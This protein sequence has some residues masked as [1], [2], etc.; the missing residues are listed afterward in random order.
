MGH[1]ASTN[2]LVAPWPIPRLRS[3][4]R[5]A[6]TT[7]KGFATPC[8]PHGPCRWSGHP[9]LA[10]PPPNEGI[11]EKARVNLRV[12][13]GHLPLKIHLTSMW[14]F[15]RQRTRNLLT[16]EWHWQFQKLCG[17]G[18]LEA[19]SKKRSN[20]GGVKWIFPIFLSNKCYPTTHKVNCFRMKELAMAA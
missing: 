14:A 20:F 2:W 19:K 7:L 1:G 12:I 3:Q 5:V 4:I 9:Q 6:E 15:F 17:G 18:T 11:L 13:W 8:R 10:G 16:N